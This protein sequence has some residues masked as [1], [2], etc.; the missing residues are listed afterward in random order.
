MDSHLRCSPHKV[1]SN[2]E[3]WWYEDPK[4]ITVVHEI[5]HG[6][7]GWYE[8]TDSFVI[9]WWVIRRALARK[10]REDDDG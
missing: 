8:R 2:S 4:G 9:P 6:S 3:V 10:D 5:R 7:K 1:R